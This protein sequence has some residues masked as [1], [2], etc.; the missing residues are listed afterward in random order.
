M[1]DLKND[2]EERSPIPIGSLPQERA[3]LLQAARTHLHR[4]P[5]EQHADLRLRA[6]LR[7]IVQ[8]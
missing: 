1:Y 3:R 7:E 6:R 5:H 2:P 4:T 8:S